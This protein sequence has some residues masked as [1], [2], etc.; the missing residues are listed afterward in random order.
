MKK[1]LLFLAAAGI[2]SAAAITLNTFQAFAD[3]VFISAPSSGDRF[4]ATGNN[5]A[6]GGLCSG[7]STGADVSGTC[8]TSG[9]NAQNVMTFTLSQLSTLEIFLQDYLTPGDQYEVVLYSD[10]TGT[11]PIGHWDS[12]S[13]NLN[14][15]SPAQ[16]CY[17]GTSHPAYGH[18]A[19]TSSSN[20]CLDVTTGPLVAGNY[21]IT[22]WDI[23]LSY[24]GGPTF[25]GGTPDS[26]YT[27]ASFGMVLTTTAVP[28]PEP[29]AFVLLG[30]GG[31]A[32]GLIR[33]R[34]AK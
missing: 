7:V 28:V 12:S 31:I 26:S 23:L 9:V 5:G 4:H 30:L 20:S 3:A 17:I 2:S 32:L 34:V 11:T 24:I 13:V 29:G 25:G 15:S 33:R 8:P 19:S 22:V 27:P 6:V 14:G 21:S 1:V 16:A 18:T 10:S